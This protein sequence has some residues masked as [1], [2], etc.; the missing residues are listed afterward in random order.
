MLDRLPAD[1]A[2]LVEEPLVLAVELLKGVVGQHR[3]VGLLGHLQDEGIAATDN[4]GRRH[5]DFAG[6]D[7]LFELGS[8]AFVDAVRKRRIDDHRDRFEVAF[9]HDASNCLIELSQARKAAPFGGDVR[10]VDDEMTGGGGTHDRN[11]EAPSEAK[12]WDLMAIRSAA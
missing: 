8:F 5:D 11:S 3:C 9:A 10:S 2:T 4:A 6:I 12:P 1:E 7:G